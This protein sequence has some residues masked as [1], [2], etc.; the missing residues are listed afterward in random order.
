[1][2]RYYFSVLLVLLQSFA[3]QAVEVVD[4]RGFRTTLAHAPQRIV[5]LL[6]SLTETI[7]ELGY[8][9][10]LVGVDRYSNF[11]TSLQS[12]PQL[13]GGMDPNIE[14]IVALKPDVVLMAKSSRAHERLEALGLKVV[15]LEPKTYAD[16][17]RVTLTLGQL[18][19]VA[20]A[21]L[22]VAQAI[23]G[24][25]G[26][27]AFDDYR[28]VLALPGLQAVSVCVPTSMYTEVTMQCLRQ[29]KHVL[30]EKPIAPT[31]AEAEQLYARAATGVAELPVE[32]RPAI[33][34]ARL[35]YAQ[36]GREV[37]RHG[38][39]SIS[40]RAVVSARRK[41]FLLLQA[42]TV[43]SH[44]GPPVDAGPALPEAAFLVDAVVRHD[45]QHGVVAEQLGESLLAREFSLAL[46]A[47][48]RLERMDQRSGTV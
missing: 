4:D 37:Q 16:V 17:Q 22:A 12:L 34:A 44:G 9:Q 6:P 46:R 3:A 42:I 24:Q 14:A 20:D 30:L 35:M 32:C 38:G 10:R 41:M 33:H 15:A 23:A 28:K 5:S 31:V 45:R 18:L 1:M 27:E 21:N 13:G 26:C 48:E 39:D 43:S 36:I 25:Y 7:C 8:C 2:K 47:F 29:G 40:S 11:P 19:A